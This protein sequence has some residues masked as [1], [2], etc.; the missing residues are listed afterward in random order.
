MIF[1]WQLF[2]V[3]HA[4]CQTILEVGP[5]KPYPTLPDA[6]Q[7]ALPGDTIQLSP[8]I[9]AGG[10]Y[11]SSL[12]GNADA[13]IT[14]RGD[15]STPV[16]IKGGTNAIQFTDPA[17]LIL[18]NLRIREQTGNGLNIDDGGSYD[19]PAHHVVIRNCVFEDM[20][21]TGNNDL[22]KLSGLD[23][24]LIT[25]CTFQRG[26]G[27]GSGVDMVG[28]HVGTMEML[29]FED[30]GSNSIQ[31]KGGSRYLTIRGSLFKDGG[32][33]SLNLGGSTGAAFF[34]PIGA[35]YEAA[36]IDV[37]ANVFV[38][39]QAPIA[40]VGSQGV[41][42]WNNTIY[43]PEKWVI[44]ILQ[45]STDTSFYQAVGYG[46]F[47]NN[48]VIVDNNLSTTSNVGPNTNA[49]SFQFAHNL[50]YHLDQPGW[51][52]PFLPVPEVNGLIQM[53]PLLADPENGN[54]HLTDTSPAIS[55]GM[56]QPETNWKDFND[57]PFHMPP[58]IGA[59]EWTGTTSIKPQNGQPVTTSYGPNPAQSKLVR[60]GV[61]FRHSWLTDIMGRWVMN[62]HQE[63]FEW[64]IHH[65][66]PGIYCVFEQTKS[67]PQLVQKIIIL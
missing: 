55:A 36:D 18:E 48:L 14:I 4:E 23:S 54:M 20:A 38:G 16:T 65:L 2:L 52:G 24:F 62:F 49:A 39:S 13:W 64:D 59:L 21:A 58:G 25:D 29:T 53:D 1:M 34:R 5:G 10:M 12:Q 31:A 15:G 57:T 22:L 33:R 3:W 17:Y 6:A 7:D 8:G 41:R 9:H 26:A 56:I 27:G 44:R 67:G 30:M 60:T 46:E 50:W 32:L 45:E 37:F 40:W 47:V 35:N 66:P 42:V 61:A 51:L 43:R 63:E 19:S 11:V 28:C